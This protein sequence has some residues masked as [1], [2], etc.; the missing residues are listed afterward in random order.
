M[1]AKGSQMSMLRLT[2]GLVF[3]VVPV[4]DLMLL[5]KIGQGIG[6]LGTVALVLGTALTGAFIISRQSLAVVSRTMEALSEGR[7]PLEPVLDGL[8][9]LLAGALLVTP[10]LITDLAA[11][12]LLVPP[13]RRVIA[14]AAMRW[15][16]RRARLHIETHGF[17]TDGFD[18]RG[19]SGPRGPRRPGF[20]EGPVIEG[21][22]K[23]V[24]EKPPHPG[25]R[26]A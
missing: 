16:V 25:R 4:V 24:D 1:E 23:R 26:D 18:G 10:G 22:F 13:L 21:E 17:E 11:L 15:L 2:I 8:A 20:A 12:V 7:P 14:R 6:V 19:R 5:V 3:I 9:L